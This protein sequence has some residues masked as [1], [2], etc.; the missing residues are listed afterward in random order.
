VTCSTLFARMLDTVPRGVQLTEVVQP[1]AAK[2]NF[3]TMA[4]YLNGTLGVSASVR[5]RS[6]ADTFAVA[7][8]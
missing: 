4:R 7:E 6:G 3:F 2:P 1:I 5:V 8:G